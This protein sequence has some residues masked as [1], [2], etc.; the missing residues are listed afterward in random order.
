[1]RPRH[2]VRIGQGR[3][4]LGQHD[5]FLLLGVCIRPRESNPRVSLGVAAG[6]GNPAIPGYPRNLVVLRFPASLLVASLLLA[7]AP[8]L[9]RAKP[10]TPELIERAE[11]GGQIGPSKA[12]LYRTYA[13]AAPERLP[14]AFRSAAPWDGTLT[15]LEVRRH[16]PRLREA[17]RDEIQALLAPPASGPSCS[18]SS[19]TQAN[20]L[21]TT[22][23]HITYDGVDA[24]LTAAG[25][26]AS[27]EDSWQKEVDSFGW[28]APPVLAANPAPG[29]RYHV[30][31][32][33]LGSGLYGFVSPQGTYAG[34]VG[35]NPA[36]AWD[37]AD[38]YASC[39][40][41]NRDYSGFPSTPQASLDS[42][43]AH[44]FNH[45]I[46][47]GYGALA[48][49]NVPDDV[50]V[51][52]GATWMEDEVHDAADDNRFYLWPVFRDSMGDYDNSPYPY[53][54]T[55]RGMTERY[56]AGSAGGAEQVMQDFW[57][58]TSQNAKSNQEAMAAALGLRG[59]TLAD[60]FHAYAVAAKFNRPCAGGYAYPYC[61][62]EGAGYVSIAGATSV[63][64]T[65][66]SVGASATS[67]VED[68]HALAWVALPSSTGP[69]DV[70]LSNTSAGG[71][72]RGTVAC[73]T[74]SGL[75]LSALPSVAASGQS[76]SLVGFNPVGCAARVLVV[77]NQSQ[78]AAN[79]TS[80]TSRSF[81]VSTA[82]AP[83]TMH[84][85]SV[86]K[87]GSG[88]GT[89]TSNPAGITCGA[90]CSQSYT[91]GTVVTLA[92][93]P[94]AGSS[95]SGW[96]GACSGMSSCS[97]T[98]SESRSVTA[99]FDLVPDNTPP[100]TTI[101][102]GPSG[103]TTDSTP[104]FIF[105]SSEP[106]STFSCQIDS[107]P[108][109]SCGSPYTTD[110]LAEGQHTFSVTATDAADNT[111]PSPATRD[112]TVAGAPP[113]D[114]DPPETTI[115]DG[116][117][118]DTTDTT[119]T[120]AFGSDE[121]N[122]TFVCQV[123]QALPGPCT[124]P[125]TT[126]PLG[127]GTHAFSV[128]ARDA[129]GNEDPT[130]A[131]RQFTVL[132]TVPPAIAIFRLSPSVF[133]AARSGPALSALVGTHI[134]V[135]LSEAATVTFRVTRLMA[136]RRVGGRCVRPTTRNRSQP[137]CVRSVLQRGRIVRE[138]APGTTRLRYRGRLAG[139]TLPA[140]RYRLLARARDAAGN[141][142]S[143]RRAPFLIVR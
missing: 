54:I 100:D 87:T 32:D 66:A 41:L 73:D 124:S 1:M 40:V 127:S 60:S 101:T 94:A 112:F 67:S 15:L 134:S 76:S 22:H 75:Q 130:P 19:S 86:S 18:S 119:P 83:P 58:L 89:V 34:F 70:T 64:A 85:L 27:L 10:P 117:S 93:T 38:A 62:E 26:A 116:V 114:Q 16:L 118:G 109:V 97:V 65:V 44:E 79:P 92:A 91:A 84:L 51:E 45:S 129:A 29:N 52:G 141:L 77:T 115:S 61:F 137:R 107:E 102:G 4:K 78:T 63:H 43:T 17:A 125:Y 105:T 128:Y 33:D 24:G 126:Q 80:S 135:A 142:S 36:T 122:S 14:A 82:G 71:Q 11:Q 20:A 31:I 50:F 136:G 39:M 88:N 96:S 3:A 98:M 7:A 42:T 139:R 123:D 47:F 110:A 120:F 12:D 25:Y 35:N 30:R 143:R 95:F 132:D 72:L 2:H 111:D 104:T 121:A 99:A 28:A 131:T 49:A 5:Y 53:W 133:R 6:A 59:T 103:E 108:A 106:G 48:G 138:L 140:G 23:F 56:G 68:N 74:G 81:A 37:D 69:Y 113:P 46:Q 13:L 21:S 90:D 9:A 8:A 55:F 57:E